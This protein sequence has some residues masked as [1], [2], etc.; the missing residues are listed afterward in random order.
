MILAVHDASD[1]FM[2]STRLYFEAKLPNWF[3]KKIM[4]C[5][6]I[7]LVFTSWIY[8]RLLVFPICLL[9]QV[10]EKIPCALD[11]WYMIKW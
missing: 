2:A 6:M 3:K 8:L 10:Y 7:I 9:G 1:I 11:E 4:D 5:I